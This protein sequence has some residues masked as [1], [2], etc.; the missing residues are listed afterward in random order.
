MRARP[1]SGVLEVDAA[2]LA[3]P[4]AVARGFRAGGAANFR[5]AL[6]RLFRDSASG[7]RGRLDSGG[8][9]TVR[10]FGHGRTITATRGTDTQK[11]RELVLGVPSPAWGQA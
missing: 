7:I 9:G 6:P 4:V 11:Q 5:W 2:P 3:F 1:R 10:C 8:I